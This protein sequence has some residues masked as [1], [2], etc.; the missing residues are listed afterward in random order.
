VTA[1]RPLPLADAA[2]PDARV[3]ISETFCSVQGEGSLTGVPSWFCRLSGCNLRCRWCDTPYASW[4]PEGTKRTLDDLVREATATG[5]R[6]AVLT[7]GEPL[8]FPQIVPL[9]Q[10]LRAAGM[11]V[12]IETAGTLWDDA[13]QTDLACDLMSI[14]PK[15][16]N[17]TPTGD[18]RDPS[19]AW[20]ARHEQRRLSRDALHGLAD[21]SG[22]AGWDR[23]LKFVVAAPADLPEVESVLGL[24][25]GEGDPRPLSASEVM[26]MPEGVAV[27]EPGATRWA[28]D[29]CVA[30]G[31]RYCHRLHIELFGHT[32]GT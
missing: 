20:A 17:S 27:H 24:I 13:W 29:A 16:A 5:V 28:V 3:L 11:H 30:R 6:H 12:T 10:R 23:Q 26:L 1:D 31:W 7:G 9:S 21:V 15:L 25:A 8:L 19:G 32:R 4:S 2:P 22:R 18:D 14:S